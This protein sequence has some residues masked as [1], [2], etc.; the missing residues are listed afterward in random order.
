M[1]KISYKLTHKEE[2]NID[3]F[4]KFIEIFSNPSLHLSNNWMS[5]YNNENKE[6]LF[7]IREYRQHIINNIRKLYTL[8]EFYFYEKILN[9][10]LW[11]LIK[12]LRFDISKIKMKTQLYTSCALYADRSFSHKIYIT[13]YK[14][15]RKYVFDKYYQIS[16]IEIMRKI[17]NV[18]RDK[19]LYNKV[20]KNKKYFKDIKDN[21]LYYPSDYPFPNVNLLFYNENAEDVWLN[22]IQKLY[23]NNM[24][25]DVI[26][27]EWYLFTCNSI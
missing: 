27:N 18:M 2:K 3:N 9:K 7:S 4:W 6:H 22:R 5:I 1:S 10:L 25:N 21:T 12:Y 23:F 13:N 24:S 19:N 17:F 20:M 26:D 8:E 11:N 16:D 15:N 14:H